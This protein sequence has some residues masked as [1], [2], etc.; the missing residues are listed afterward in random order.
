MGLLVELLVSVLLAVTIFYCVSLDRKLKRFKSDEDSLRK[1]I[2]EL[3][4]ATLKAET[5]VPGLR[6]AT[7]EAEQSL[8]AVL[9]QSDAKLEAVE[10]SI[11]TADDVIQRIA[12]IV[13]ANRDA[14]DAAR[15]ALQQKLEQVSSIVTL[16]Q[17][18]DK[19]SDAARAARELADKARDRKMAE[20]A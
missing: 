1:V 4:A 19:L 9:K 8:G 14:E 3:T 17:R 6:V 18:Q 2:G 16:P 11:R 20:A 13:A 10:N 5:A 7:V 12:Q 15:E